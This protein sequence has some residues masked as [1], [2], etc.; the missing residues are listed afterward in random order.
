MSDEEKLF[1]DNIELVHYVLHSM[2]HI[3]SNSQNY[4]DCFQ[5]GCIGLW[6][7]CQ[8]Y[9]KQR[10]KFSTY[11]T[12]LIYNEVKIN[13]RLNFSDKRKVHMTY[14]ESLD[15]IRDGYKESKID[16][17]VDD[18]YD[19]DSKI[20]NQQRIERILK[21]DFQHKD[22]F[23]DYLNGYSQTELCEKYHVS[24]PS[25]NKR[26]SQIKYYLKGLHEKGEI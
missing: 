23:I 11:A 9:N 13:F 24:Q 21:L 7:A 14:I 12:K 20:E 5:I 4:E 19:I 15:M 6:K 18:S 16:M 8:T 22:M 3:N 25:I 1:Y 17:I 2:I 10:S 26:L